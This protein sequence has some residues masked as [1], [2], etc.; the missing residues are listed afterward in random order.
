MDTYMYIHTIKSKKDKTSHKCITQGDT[1]SFKASHNS[2]LKEHYLFFFLLQFV[3]L[4]FNLD[5]VKAL[6]LLGLI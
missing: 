1:E 2:H 6:W 5:S 3:L 4:Y